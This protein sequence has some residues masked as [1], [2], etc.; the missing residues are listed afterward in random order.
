MNASHVWAPLS[1][2]EIR[3]V[4]LPA[5][6]PWWIGGGYAIELAVG[7]AFREHED[8]DVL[9]LRMDQ[10]RVRRFLTGWECWAADPPGHLREWPPDEELRFGVHDVWCRVPGETPWCFSLMLDESDGHTWHSR[11]DTRVSKPL[12]ELTR[13]GADGLRYLVPDVQLYYKAKNTRPKDELDFEVALPLLDS[14][15]RTWL[16]HAI[17]LTYGVSHPWLS[18]IGEADRAKVTVRTGRDEDW[19][20]MCHVFT[21]AARAAWGHILPAAT[22]EAL[23]T[24]ERW[25]PG[26]GLEVLVAQGANRV[27]GFVCLQASADNDAQAAV[28]E[29]DA[30]YVHPS[31]WGTGIGQA[32]LSAATR[33]LAAMGFTEATLWTEHRNHRPLRFYRAGGW[34]LDDAE[35]RRMFRGTELLE[36]RLRLSLK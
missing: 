18:R 11:R 24:S 33:Q 20:A 19:E 6:F 26:R 31:A 13:Y 8:I 22:L 12:R 27:V 32:L 25:R 7:R 28:G 4:F 17:T 29:I 34:K 14:E 36:L 10:S 35:R 23:S 1:I 15:Q 3:D 16:R 2:Q 9:V 21:E 5:D 30:C